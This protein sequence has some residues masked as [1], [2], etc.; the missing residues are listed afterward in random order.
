[1]DIKWFFVIIG[2]FLTFAILAGMYFISTFTLLQQQKY[3]E[4]SQKGA[5]ERFDNSTVI[6]D[7]L[8]KNITDLKKGL[9]PILATV[10]NATD[11]RIQQDIHYNQTAQDF[12]KIQ[13]V[14]QIK[15]Q[16]HIT[17]GQMNQTVNQILGILTNNQTTTNTGN[18][19]IIIEN[20]T[21][22]IPIPPV[23]SPTPLP[24]PAPIVNNDTNKKEN[25]TGGIVI[26]NITDI[27]NDKGLIL[28]RNQ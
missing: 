24:V 17:L 20:T 1:L 18:G 10:K 16:D 23:P 12:K 4:D 3:Y 21:K 13:Q 26:E 8:F 11:M 5:I 2:I 19:S 22:P 6:H 25:D 14:L 7:F 27:G 28:L 9:D 15:L